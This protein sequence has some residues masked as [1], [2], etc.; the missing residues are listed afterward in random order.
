M[1]DVARAMPADLT[2]SVLAPRHDRKGF[3]CGV[4]ELDGYLQRQARQDL[5]RR[6]A[7][8]YILADAEGKIAGYYTLSNF[9]IELSAIPAAIAKKLPYPKIPA[10]LIGRLAVDNGSRGRGLGEHLLMDA[11][12]RAAGQSEVLGAWAV[13][14]HSKSDAAAE[15][16]GKYGFIPFP[17]N[18]RHLYL[19]MK[20]VAALF[21]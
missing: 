16:Y 12:N 20:T 18:R 11:L 10:V 2:I 19:P 21:E 15:F 7:V 9:T 5:K 13:V 14:V 6:L 4:P 3:R 17:D 1:A 8:P